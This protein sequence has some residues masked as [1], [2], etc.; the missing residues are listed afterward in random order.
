MPPIRIALLLLLMASVPVEAD[1]APPAVTTET[2]APNAAGTILGRH[3]FTPDNED[4]GLLVD[5]LAGPDGTPK[6]GIVDVGGFM[7]VGTKRIAI[8]WALLHVML[9]SGD[10]RIVEDL[11]GDEATAAP[12]FRGPDGPIIVTGPAPKK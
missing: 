9:D 4:I 12:E 10:P 2:L 11:T 6:A 3:V 7:G 8:A 5:I 1:D